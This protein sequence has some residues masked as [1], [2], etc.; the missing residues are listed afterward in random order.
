MAAESGEG[1]RSVQG[2]DS[3]LA[4]QPGGL[5]G[6]ATFDREVQAWRARVSGGVSP[7]AFSLA[8]LDWLAHLAGL[9]GR[10]TE[11]AARAWRDGVG[12]A[13]GAAAAPGGDEPRAEDRRFAAP[14]WRQWPFSVFSRVFLMT[15]RWWQE[16]TSGVPGVSRHHER[17]VSFAAR[18]LL[19]AVSPANFFWTNPEVLKA[20]AEQR[21]ANLVRGANLLAGD[22]R[23][24]LTGAR[25]ASTE[26]FIPGRS[27]AVTPGRVV[28]RN[29]LIEL[30]QYKPATETVH[31]EPVLIVSAWIMKYYILDLSPHNSLVKYLVD[32]GHTVFVV[33]WRNPGPEDR[34][35]DLEDY[36]EQGV[37]AAL[38]AI[39]A[40]IPGRR[41][42][43]VGYCLGGTM[44]MITSAAMARDGDERLATITMFATETDFT[45]PGE[46]GVFLDESQVADLEAIM[47]E[48]GY[49]DSAQMAGAFEML[50]PYELIWSRA[51]GEYLL[52]E[53]QLP[54][55]LMAWNTDG[56][57]LPYR[58][59]SQYLHR[60]FLC[61]D[62]FEGRYRAAGRPVSLSD[63]RAPVFMV[64]TV[65][66]HV[67]PWRSV[68]KLNLVAETE[69][70]FL[71][72]SGGHNAGIVS[73]P[74]YRGRSFQ[75]ATRPAGAPYPDPGLWAAATPRQE[76]SWWP[77][78]E[79][80][81][82]QH[83]SEREQPPAMGAPDR[84]YPPLDDAPGTY[85][86]QR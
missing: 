7:V 24:L 41:V 32:H 35:L 28:F 29:H 22:W 66:D 71:L 5:A 11:L 18:Q 1:G 52:G 78:W 26:A 37:L 74:G 43:A 51:I 16:A 59:H 69:L 61:N 60:L 6:L 86:L 50:R 85:V 56:T 23:R 77:V 17:V 73:E 45:E 31:A 70:T 48:Q 53:R 46:L 83:S 79:A 15:E 80:W 4:V 63:I 44:L 13:A 38:D 82:A 20:T 2:P 84:G 81:L 54:N 30:I 65:R 62:L 3:G 76:G 10:Q 25:P 75:V 67:A 42:H 39:S 64:G 72:A 36:R 14:G 33:S 9:P 40:I 47:W 8:Y 57:R 12:L 34:D 55:D 58:M 68:Y 21:G 49:L 27:V 19:D